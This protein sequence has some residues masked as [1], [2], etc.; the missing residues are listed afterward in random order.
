MPSSARS[1]GLG[2]AYYTTDL[3]L[4]NAGIGEATAALK[5]LGN[6]INGRHGPEKTF[7]IAQGT[8]VTFSD[9]LRS[10]FGLEQDLGAIQ[11]SAALR[12]PDYTSTGSLTVQA[13]TSTPSSAGTFGQ[14]VPAAAD[15]QLIEA[16]TPRSII[17][18]REDTGF[19]TNLI[20][21]NARETQTESHVT[22]ISPVGVILASRHLTLHPLGMVQ[23]TRVVRELG[24]GSDISGA[25]L[26]LSTP[27]DGGAFAAYVALIDNVTNDPRALL[28]Q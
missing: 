20:L 26:R 24:V 3:T 27:T 4:A 25:R 6:Q 17:G 23:L 1:P 2:G 8:S 21:A 14:S 12:P 7:V 13:Q 5:F 9:V 22:L 10:L 15:G 18:I 11:V 19:R 28:P 16:S